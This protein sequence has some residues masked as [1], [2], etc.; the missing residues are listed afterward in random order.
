VLERG[1]FLERIGTE[2]VF[3]TKAA[4]I[5]GIYPRL[6]VETCRRCRARI[7]IECARLPDGSAREEKS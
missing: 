2:N 7:F 6:D 1:G 4:A 5:A 3:A